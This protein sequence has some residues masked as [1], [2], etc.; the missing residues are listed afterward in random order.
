MNKNVQE[1]R[2]KK[3]KEIKTRNEL[4]RERRNIVRRKNA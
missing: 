2:E 4:M 3:T 1:E